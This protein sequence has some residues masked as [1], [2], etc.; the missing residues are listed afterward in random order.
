MTKH[1]S[2]DYKIS[3]FQYYLTKNKNQLIVMD[4][5]SSHINQK[6]KRFGK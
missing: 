1:K 2:E 3:A 6:N 4:N 5:A